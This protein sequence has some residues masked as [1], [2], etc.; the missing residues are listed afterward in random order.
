L[1]GGPFDWFRQGHLGWKVSPTK[2][3]SYID[4]ADEDRNLYEWTDYSG[5]CL[6]RTDAEHCHSYSNG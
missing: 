2:T 6:P 1:L 4:Q 3:K 5:K